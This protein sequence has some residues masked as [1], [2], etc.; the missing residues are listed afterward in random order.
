M[1][2]ITDRGEVFDLNNLP[3]DIRIINHNEVYS[4]GNGIL[5]L[6]GRV[7]KTTATQTE[8]QRISNL[9]VVLNNATKYIEENYGYKTAVAFIRGILAK[10]QCIVDVYVYPTKDDLYNCAMVDSLYNIDGVYIRIVDVRLLPKAFEINATL[11]S[12]LLYRDKAFTYNYAMQPLIELITG[13][14]YRLLNSID[15]RQ[16]K[17]EAIDELRDAVYNVVTNWLT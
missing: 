13:N 7:V 9:R 17:D 3:K 6:I 14:N 11:R 12:E 2:I 10:D 8:A 15:N 16:T 4:G 5:G 1:Y